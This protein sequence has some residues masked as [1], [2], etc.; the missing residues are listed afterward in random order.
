LSASIVVALPGFA[1]PMR[2]KSPTCRTALPG[3]GGLWPRVGDPKKKQ[4]SLPA[5]R[6]LAAHRSG[7]AMAN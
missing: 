6:R 2:G 4:A 3:S 1:T 7:R 5:S